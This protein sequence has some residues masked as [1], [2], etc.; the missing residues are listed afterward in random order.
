MRWSCTCESPPVIALT[1][2]FLSSSSKE[3]D[4]STEALLLR[5]TLSKYGWCH[6]AI[7]SSKL[8]QFQSF[9]KSNFV[10]LFE[11]DIVAAPPPDGA[12]YR[13]RTAE[14]GSS[15]EADGAEPKQ[16]W[17][18]QRCGGGGTTPLHESMNALHSIAVQVT[19]MLGLPKDTFLRE[20]ACCQQ[21]QGDGGGCCSLTDK[22]NGDL[23]RI[24]LYDPVAA[25]TMGSSPHTDWG[26]WTVVWQDDV[27]GLQTYCP[28]HETYVDVKVPTKYANKDA[29]LIYFVVHV[30]D[31]TSLALGH[32]SGTLQTKD[33]NDG[34]STNK[35]VVFPSPRHRVICPQEEPR[36]SLVYFAYPPPSISLAEMETRF[37]EER[38]KNSICHHQEDDESSKETVILYDSYYLLQNQNP[39]GGEAEDPEQVYRS[40]RS[41][42]LGECFQAKWEQVQRSV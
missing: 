23:L 8:R 26:S 4:A 36:V 17:E 9:S 11:K 27:G 30:G 5:S 7:D 34:S 22:C 32:A 38:T 40:I 12:V 16:S 25:K 13:G 18:V 6:V 24:F 42:P 28:L 2:S 21:H 29:K 1:E 39:G 20:A 35:A 14:S 37:V 15:V 19:K 33:N 41:K 31:V 3:A 10:K